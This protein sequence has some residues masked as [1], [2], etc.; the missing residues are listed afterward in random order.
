MHRIYSWAAA[1][2]EK[3]IYA[4]IAQLTEEIRLLTNWALYLSGILD[5]SIWYLSVFNIIFE[6]YNM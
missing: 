6:T 4:I 3:E 2:A 5:N 1:N